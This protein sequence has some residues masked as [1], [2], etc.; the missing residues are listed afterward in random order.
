MQPE[1]AAMHGRWGVRNFSRII[2]LA[3]SAAIGLAGCTS[4]FNSSGLSVGKS[5]TYDQFSSDYQQHSVVAP[6][7][8]LDNNPEPSAMQKFGSAVAAVPDKV[9]STVKSGAVKA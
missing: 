9:G 1:F 6:G 5:G 2:A 3:S 4:P 8:G 7:M